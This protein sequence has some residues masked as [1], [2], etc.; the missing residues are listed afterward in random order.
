MRWHTGDFLHVTAADPV[1][2]E[3]GGEFAAGDGLEDLAGGLG[4]AVD[5]RVSERRPASV[6]AFDEVGDEHMP[7]QQRVTGA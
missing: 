6:V 7:V 1:D 4:G 2:T 5:L 3:A